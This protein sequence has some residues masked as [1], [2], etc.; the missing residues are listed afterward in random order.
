MVVVQ[1]LV[2]QRE[3]SE[4]SALRALPARR[5]HAGIFTTSVTSASKYVS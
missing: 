3:E 1:E 5:R 2:E 4:Q